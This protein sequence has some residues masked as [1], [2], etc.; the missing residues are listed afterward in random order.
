MNDLPC[1]AFNLSTYCRT[2][3]RYGYC[4]QQ[5]NISSSLFLLEV[6]HELSNSHKLGSKVE[7]EVLF[8]TIITSIFSAEHVG[9]GWTD[10]MSVPPFRTSFSVTFFHNEQRGHSTTTAYCT[11]SFITMA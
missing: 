5:H 6:K 2:C 8:Q 9:G 10:L 7:A 4:M 11:N 3:H 1:S